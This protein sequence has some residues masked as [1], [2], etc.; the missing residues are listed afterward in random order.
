MVPSGDPR[1]TVIGAAGEAQMAA[2]SAGRDGVFTLG[3]RAKRASESQREAA[4]KR[5]AYWR[6]APARLSAT[7]S[8]PGP[9]LATRS[10]AQAPI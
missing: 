4:Q 9:M 5:A 10:V 2:A 7:S 1:F 6:G 3:T 8:G